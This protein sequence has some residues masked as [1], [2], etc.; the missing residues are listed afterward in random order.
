MLMGPDHAIWFVVQSDVG[1]LDPVSHVVSRYS[2]PGVHLPSAMAVGPDGGLW[3][4]S[5]SQNGEIEGDSI[6]RLDPTSKTFTHHRDPQIREV[7]SISGAGDGAVWFAHG[8]GVGRIDPATGVVSTY[9]IP[10]ASGTRVV[11]SG[12][13]GFV[14]FVTHEG[15]VGQLDLATKAVT[16][17]PNLDVGWMTVGRVGNDGILWFAGYINGTLVRVDPVSRVKSTFSGRKVGSPGD[18]AV[19]PDGT[20]W[21][22]NPV[23]GLGPRDL[24]FGWVT[25]IDPVTL[26]VTSYRDTRFYAPEGIVVG[27]DGVVWFG[28]ANAV[29]RLVPR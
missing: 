5:S 4:A 6:T 10:G 3:I 21:F 14:W 19:A 1:R 11:V 18:I 8:A 29:G 9:P 17:Y 27:P 25:K 15:V 22:S 12:H 26:V 16:T 28:D 2:D 23:L 20:V 13:D 7:Q 24:G